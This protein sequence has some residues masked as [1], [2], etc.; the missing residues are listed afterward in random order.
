M[1]VCTS[2]QADNHPTTHFTG[3]MPFLPPNQQHQSTEDTIPRRYRITADRGPI[4]LV[5]AI[6]YVIGLFYWRRAVRHG[7]GDAMT[8]CNGYATM[9]MMNI[10]LMTLFEFIGAL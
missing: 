10:L 5:V 1:Q 4:E 3:R 9:M 6:S 2:L 8:L 7:H